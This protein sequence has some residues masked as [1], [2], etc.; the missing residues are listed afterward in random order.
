M[1]IISLSVVEDT[2]GLSQNNDN[3]KEE[4]VQ[5]NC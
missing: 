2:D 3:G 1:H 4:K 5:D